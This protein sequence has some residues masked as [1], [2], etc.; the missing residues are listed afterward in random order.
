MAYISDVSVSD[1]TSEL[2]ISRITSAGTVHF[3]VLS[4]LIQRASYKINA[5]LNKSVWLHYSLLLAM[6]GLFL[7]RFLLQVHWYHQI[8]P[9][10]GQEMM[11][12]KNNS[13]FIRDNYNKQTLESWTLTSFESFQS[14]SS[15]QEKSIKWFS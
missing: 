4:Q 13:K 2:F 7:E 1:M 12:S 5:V 3:N 6:T 14:V 11:A 10:P 9:S 15:Y 8:L